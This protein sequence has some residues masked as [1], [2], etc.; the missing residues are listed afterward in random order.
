MKWIKLSDE[1]PISGGVYLAT[2][3]DDI[4]ICGYWTHLNP[5][6]A[7]IDNGQPMIVTHWM[8]LPAPPID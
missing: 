1:K 2:N 6:W 7:N 5:Q 8:P 3:E 4:Q